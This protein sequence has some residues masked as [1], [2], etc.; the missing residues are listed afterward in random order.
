MENINEKPKLM[1]KLFD[2]ISEIKMRIEKKGGAVLLLDFD[3][4]LSAIAKTPDE[5]FISNENIELVK[6][7]VELFP[8]AVITGRTLEDIKKKMDIKDLFYIASHGL[9][10][11]EEGKYHVKPI[12]KE[13]IAAINSAKE[14]I[15]PLVSRYPGMILED[16]SFMFALH[17]RIMKPELIDAFIKEATSIL[18]PI[19]E[20]NNLRLDHNMKT[21]ELRP[22]INWDKGDSAI[23]AEK[24]FNK[25]VGG[26]F[27]PIY[28]GDSLTDEDAF[29]AIR[30]HGITIRIGENKESAAE[31]YMEDQREVAL[32]LKWL[33]S[34]RQ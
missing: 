32:F 1:K 7:C 6:K 15:R 23:F 4:V 12:P 16:K 30:E 5:A 14:R 8:V 17:Y 22:D 13:T 29:K 21:F 9:E 20:Q 26:K 24:Y 18:E 25:K 28:I 19:V 2:N 34:F 10:W 27:I 31:W 11:E 33:L 3:G